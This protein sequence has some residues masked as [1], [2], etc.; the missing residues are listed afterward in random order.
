MK[1]VNGTD[2]KESVVKT[3]WNSTAKILQDKFYN[4]FERR[5]DPFKDAVFKAARSARNAKRRLLQAQPEKRMES[6]CAL[7]FNELEAMRQICD[8]DCPDGLQKK[9]FIVASVELAWRGGEG[10]NALIHH[11]KFELQNDGSETGRIE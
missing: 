4:E 3:M 1:K 2:Y 11:F 10:C 5:I 6:A 7:E 8:E 9:F